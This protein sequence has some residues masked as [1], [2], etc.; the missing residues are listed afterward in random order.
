MPALSRA[1]EVESGMRIVPSFG[2]T[3]QLAQQIENGG[4]FD[5]FLAADTEHVD[6]LVKAGIAQERAVYA[7]GELVVWTRARA[8]IRGIQDLTR[9][10]VHSVA[11]AKPELAPY[12]RAA[13]EAMQSANLWTQL[14]PKLVYAQ[15]IS[16]ARTYVETGNCD[17][18]YTALSLVIR[19]PGQ[20]ARVDPNGYRPI[21][22]A[23][24]LVAHSKNLDAARR[25]AR[26]LLSPAARSIWQSYGYKAPAN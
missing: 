24:G 9:S 26:F 6:A 13:V 4:P 21:D 12:G 2:A 17:A 18:A 23:L 15:N 19:A 7:R 1:F 5:V 22:Q 25:Y 10:D 3:A 11:V 14:Q 16:A 8:G 20:F